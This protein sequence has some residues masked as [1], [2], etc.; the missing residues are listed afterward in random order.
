[1]DL[2]R[3]DKERGQDPKVVRSARFLE[4]E[5]G[6][7]FRTREDIMLGPYQDKFDAELSASLLIARLAQLEEGKDPAPVIQA[8]ENDPSN[9][10]LR[11]AHQQKPIDLK[12]IRR[13]NQ[14]DSAVNKVQKAWTSLSNL[15]TLP[16]TLK[17][18][19]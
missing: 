17:L 9:A 13:K 7:F 4:T 8:F 19:R 6:W 16:K 12:A 18:K 1:M 15:K 5:D 14:I 3:Q 11:H 2:R 10:K